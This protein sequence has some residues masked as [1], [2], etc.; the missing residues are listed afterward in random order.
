MHE[1]IFGPL[2]PVKIYTD[3]AQQALFARH[4]VQRPW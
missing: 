1:E 3:A 2:L 4:N